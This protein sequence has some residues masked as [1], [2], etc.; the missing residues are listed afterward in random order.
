MKD[1]IRTLLLGDISF[2]IPIGSVCVFIVSLQIE[3][4]PGII[5]GLL[6]GSIAGKE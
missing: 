4:I 1:G 3:I 2:G 5:P 6:F